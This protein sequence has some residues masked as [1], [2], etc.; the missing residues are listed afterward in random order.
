MLDDKNK[1]TQL[2]VIAFSNWNLSVIDLRKMLK[3]IKGL[4]IKV[5]DLDE[6][7][8]NIFQHSSRLYCRRGSKPDSMKSV[9]SINKKIDTEID[10]DDLYNGSDCGVE[11]IQYG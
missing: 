9:T 8:L 7:L 6:T 4:T 10:S 3:A 2:E 1:N 5:N 11:K